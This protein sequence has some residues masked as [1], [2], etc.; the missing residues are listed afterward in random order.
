LLRIRER[1]G[2]KDILDKEE[3]DGRSLNRSKLVR[4]KP[5]NA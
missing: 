4:H 2:R 5:T 1:G 3:R